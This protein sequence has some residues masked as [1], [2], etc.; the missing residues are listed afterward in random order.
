MIQ[1]MKKFTS[2]VYYKEYEA[3]LEQIQE[4]GVL[5]VRTTQEGNLASVELAEKMSATDHVAELV[6]QFSALS[7]REETGKEKDSMEEVIARIDKL[8][9]LLRDG[10]NEL[11]ELRQNEAVLRP[12]GDFSPATLKQLADVGYIVGFYTCPKRSFDQEWVGLYNAIVI[13]EEGGKLYFVTITSAGEN[14]AIDAEQVMFA[15]MSLSELREVIRAREER[16]EELE[17]QLQEAARLHLSGLRQYECE[18]RSSIA[19]DRVL[20]STE[21]VADDRLMVLEGWIPANREAD[22]KQLLMNTGVYYEIRDPRKDEEVPVKLK[23]NPL[24]RLYE[25]L[26]GMYGMPGKGDSDPTSILSIFFTLFFAMCIADAGYGLLLVIL[27]LIDIHKKGAVGKVLFGVNFRLVLVLGIACIFIG[28]VFGTVFGVDISQL[29]Y[30]PEWLRSCMITGKFAGTSYDKQM[31]F[32]LFI[33]IIHISLAMTVK[34]VNSTAFNGFKE[35]LSVWGWWLMVIGS[36]AVCALTYFCVIPSET[37]MMLF[38]VVWGVSAI[39]IFLLNDIHRNPLVNIAAGLYDTYSMVSGLIGDVLSYLRLYALG[40]AGGILGATFNKLA[41]MVVD[42]D[43]YSGGV[44]AII[45]FALILVF[46]HILNIAMSCLSAFVH[47]LRLSF[48]EYFKNAG[49]EGSGTVYKPLTKVEI[50]NNK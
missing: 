22:L 47:P 4:L 26:T 25:A 29:P 33:G 2:L 50:V 35:S 14:P 37:M 46:G 31:V 5:H 7:A 32:A 3:Y 49:Y 6:A 9:A 1:K 18:L 45:G 20:L 30:T 19:F 38:Y 27:S 21:R 13:S 10:R 16:V 43:P 39:G 41:L 23:N 42:N 11:L 12:W 15:D 8:N 36:I 17:E 44:C 24:V 28:L 40:L 34:A 48:V